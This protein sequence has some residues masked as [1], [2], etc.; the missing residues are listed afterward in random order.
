MCKSRAAGLTTLDD[1]HT[2]G[3]SRKGIDVDEVDM[4]SS[5]LGPVLTPESLD[6]LLSLMKRYND[7]N[8]G[9]HQIS[10][11][12][13]WATMSGSH[14]GG[15]FS[16]SK[17]RSTWPKGQDPAP[18]EKLET[19]YCK[20]V[21][22]FI[23]DHLHNK[24]LRTFADL[25]RAL[26]TGRNFVITNTGRLA[27][28]PDS[29]QEGDSIVVLAGGKVPFVLRRLSGDKYCLLGD[30]YVYGI[31]DGEVVDGMRNGGRVWEDVDL[32]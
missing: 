8:D 7:R 5:L 25:Y 3:I 1:G 16:G 14:I 32:V 27:W 10:E 20:P 24:D 6:P 11:T 29:C 28:C 21:A 30:A 15:R 31:M 12:V 2:I 18:F 22:D 23:E 26:R 13:F 17:G 4:I 19:W 9:G